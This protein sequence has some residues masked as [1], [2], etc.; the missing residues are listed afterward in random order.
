MWKKGACGKDSRGEVT[1]GF[2]FSSDEGG[3]SPGRE[4]C[5][6]PSA[7]FQGKKN[8]C[9]TEFTCRILNLSLIFFPNCNYPT[10]F[11]MR[12]VQLT[13]KIRLSAA[14]PATASQAPPLVW[15]PDT[16]CGPTATAATSW[17]WLRTT[18]PSAGRYP[19]GGSC[20]G[21]WQHSFRSV[22]T[23]SDSW[24]PTTRLQ[25]PTV[26]SFAWIRAACSFIDLS[27][28]LLLQVTEE[29]HLRN[30]SSS[31]NTLQHTLEEASRLLKLV[32]RVSLPAGGAA[33]GENSSNQQVDRLRLKK[34]LKKKNSMC[35]R[36]QI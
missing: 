15:C 18:A 21:A 36:P 4:D 8:L 29:Q 24:I 33:V 35:H 27:L 23:H 26:H 34:N 31:M 11:Q 7:Q 32:W 5:D 10:S 22:C 25:G 1:A 17:V 2:I 28:I 13:L 16:E 12:S 20:R 30:F 9:Y 3:R 14:A 6:L 19:R